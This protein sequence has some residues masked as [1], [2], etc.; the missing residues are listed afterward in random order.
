MFLLFLPSRSPAAQGKNMEQQG[1]SRNVPVVLWNNPGTFRSLAAQGRNKKNIN[2]LFSL[3]RARAAVI[4]GPS[5]G[6][7]RCSPGSP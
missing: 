3:T 6:F 2:F 1:C 5:I 7:P 4:A